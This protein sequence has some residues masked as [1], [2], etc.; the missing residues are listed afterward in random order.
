M[1]PMKNDPQDALQFNAQERLKGLNRA[2]RFTIGLWIAF[3]IIAAVIG[4]CF[5]L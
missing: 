4:F 1:N 3:W 2:R 5:L